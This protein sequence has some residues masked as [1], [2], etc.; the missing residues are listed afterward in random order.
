MLVIFRKCIVKGLNFE[1][2]YPFIRTTWEFP[3]CLEEL[4]PYRGSPRHPHFYCLTLIH[5]RSFFSVPVSLFLGREKSKLPEKVN[6]LGE[7]IRDTHS[8]C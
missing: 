2:E 1:R 3:L 7:Q 8:V 4:S 6:I 5:A